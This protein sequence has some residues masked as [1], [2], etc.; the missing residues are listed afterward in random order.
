MKHLAIIGAGA[1]GSA[2]AFVAAQSTLTTTVW[3]RNA[4][5]VAEIN[6]TLSVIQAT[7]DLEKTVA[8]ADIIINALPAKAIREVF[9]NAKPYIKKNVIIINA[10]KGID[11][12]THHFPSQ[13]FAD[14]FS[15]EIRY[16]TA[17]GPAFAVGLLQ[18]NP[19][20][21]N[22][23]GKDTTTAYKIAQAVRHKQV[24]LVVS[25]DIIGV[26]WGGIYKNIIAIATG[27]AA[28]LGYGENTQALLFTA[29]FQEMRTAGIQ[30]GAQEQTFYQPA[31]IGDLMLTATSMKSRNFSFG[32]HLA[33]EGSVDAAIRQLSGIAEGYYT[34]QSIPYLKNKYHLKLPISDMLQG[35]IEEQKNPH[36]M[37]QTF[38]ETLL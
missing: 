32:Y 3:S 7:T 22:L 37:F 10:S 5:T 19:T 34:L 14:L 31:G 29:G 30:M 4:T 25:N 36:E 12:Q 24:H 8:D 1:W 16:F 11:P 15:E 28:G 9:T 13:I 27:L 20:I 38:L 6:H 35:I 17:S 21:M 23:A 33:K 2:L 18:K 26:E